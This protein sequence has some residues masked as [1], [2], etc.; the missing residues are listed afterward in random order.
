MTLFQI[1]YLILDSVTSLA[2]EDKKKLITIATTTQR[3]YNHAV[4]VQEY[5]KNHARDHDQVMKELSDVKA[6]LEAIAVNKNHARDYNYYV[7]KEL[8]DVKVVLENLI[9]SYHDG[10]RRLARMIELKIDC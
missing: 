7:M 2:W 10:I 6:E 8:S 9:I 5:N 4:T 3:L 1:M